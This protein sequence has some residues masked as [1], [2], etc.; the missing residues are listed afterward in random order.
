MLAPFHGQYMFLLVLPLLTT[1]QSASQ[2]G[3]LDQ[4]YTF[5]VKFEAVYVILLIRARVLISLI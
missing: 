1:Q 4:H 2:Q 5:R 3:L